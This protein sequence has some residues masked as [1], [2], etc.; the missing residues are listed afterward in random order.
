MYAAN[1][2]TPTLV[3]HSEQDYRCPIEQGE[4]LYAALQLRGV[5]T[6][7]VRFPNE[8]HGL[9]RNGKPK[10]RLQRLDEIVGWYE[11]YLGGEAGEGA[12]AGREQAAAAR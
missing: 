3:L 2:V 11:R 5:P 8:S 7:M 12:E 4:Q 10:H 9:S 6:R 1:F